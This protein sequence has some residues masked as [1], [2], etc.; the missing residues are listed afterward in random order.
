MPPTHEPVLSARD[1]ASVQ[2]ALLSR[3]V[4]MDERSIEAW[5][6]EQRHA[7][8]SFV[9]R[10]GERKHWLKVEG[11]AAKSPFAG[12]ERE[13]EALS[14]VANLGIAPD[15][16]CS[17][18]LVDGRSFLV[19]RH[20]DGL[21]LG[22]SDLAEALPLTHR[23]LT[24]LAR[25]GV[26][27]PA[28]GGDHLFSARP[29]V[30]ALLGKANS[31]F[32]RGPVIGEHDLLVRQPVPIHGSLGLDNVIISDGHTV[33]LDWEAARVGPLA[34]D[35]ATLLGELLDEGLTPQAQQWLGLAASG[36]A[37]SEAQVAGWL[38]LRG[39]NRGATGDGDALAAYQ[40]F[41]AGERI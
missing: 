36:D 21:P 10:N 14:A 37:R 32:L 39:L 19:T 25:S 9:D 24:T 12:V 27:L 41:L 11:Q 23:S 35:I 34:F 40:T 20:V 8:F 13:A 38:A 3:G 15:L 22:Q 28:H 30:H 7:S 17:G 31:A 16:V 4:A 6:G 18:V 26:D 5:A 2:E 29:D 33:F 1:R